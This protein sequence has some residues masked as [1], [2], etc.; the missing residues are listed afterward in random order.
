MATFWYGLLVV[1]F[2]IFGFL[3]FFSVNIGASTG[4]HTGVITAV[5]HNNNIIFDANLVY[6]KSSEESTQEDIYCVNDYDVLTQLREF[7][8]TKEIVTIY[9]QNDFFFWRW[10]CNG[11]ISIINNVEKEVS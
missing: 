3:T 2:I 8:K 7:S 11:G 10:D 4:Q 1:L 9:F 5:E 6:F